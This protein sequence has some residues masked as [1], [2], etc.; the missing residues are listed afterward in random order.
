MHTKVNSSAGSS[1]SLSLQAMR[2]R[3]LSAVLASVAAHQPASRARL[4]QLTGLTKTTVSSLVGTLTEGGFVREDGP[5]RDGERGRPGIAVTLDDD[6]V[7]GLGLEVN[8]DYLAAC[9]LDLGDRVRHRAVVPADNRASEPDQ[10]IQALA[11]LAAEAIAAVP[12]LLVAGAVVALPGALDQGVLRTAPNLGWTDTPV[13]EML[14][15][16]LSPDHRPKRTAPAETPVLDDLGHGGVRGTPGEASA[17]YLR[18]P[19]EMDNEANLAAL[20]E[21]RFGVGAGLGSYVHVSG[22][23]GIGGGV[24]I[25]GRIFR[26]AHGFAGEL[27]HIVVDPGG[28]PCACGGRGCLEQV[29][30]QD[31]MLRRAGADGLDALLALLDSGDATALAV[32]HD[33][34]RALGAALA[35]AVNLLDPDAVVL[36]G[37]FARLAPWAR[38]AIE[39]S[40][41][42]G[43]G[44]L[45][46]TPPAV[47]TSR[48]GS[49]AAVLGA[50]GLVLQRVLADPATL[51][52]E[53]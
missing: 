19:A 8:V 32:V 15:H 14:A 3:N 36:G 43:A 51:L 39:A 28:A 47:T 46:H 9:V 21:L 22:E 25:D 31:A 7:A 4:A 34:G 13:A 42:D 23:I 20:G 45:R 17:A 26:G 40:L 11:T 53:G 16:H 1:G 49:D 38:P 41:A 2:E 5:V 48:L 12:G 50:A 18:L 44:V 6:R 10:V 52:K 27:G 29:A 37:T 33:A 35:T 24:V 30:G